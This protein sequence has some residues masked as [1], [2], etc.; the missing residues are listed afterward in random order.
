[1]DY[2]YG[3]INSGNVDYKGVDTETAK[4]SVDNDRRTIAVD[5]LGEN[6]SIKATL[7]KDESGMYVDGEWR[8]DKVIV[9]E[10]KITRIIWT[11]L[12]A[13]GPFYAGATKDL[14][15]E[16][17]KQL[18]NYGT[19][20]ITRTIKVTQDKNY[21]VYAY[22]KKLGKLT[23]IKY[24]G[25]PFEFISAFKEEDGTLSVVAIDGIDYYVYRTDQSTNTYT[26][27]LQF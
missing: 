19:A 2:I 5:V 20:K 10:G 11:D 21:F 15:A 7:P 8:M 1:M 23:S 27:I 3:A 25:S 26:Y 13:R 9:T 14:S 4:V 6:D 16:G 18:E 22:P 24:E 17:I 12:A